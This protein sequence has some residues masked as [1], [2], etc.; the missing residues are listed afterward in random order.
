[1]ILKYQY[2]LPATF[3]KQGTKRVP[4]LIVCKLKKRY[5]RGTVLGPQQIQTL[6]KAIDRWRICDGPHSICF[7]TTSSSLK[8]EQFLK[9]VLESFSK[10]DVVFQVSNTLGFRQ[11]GFLIQFITPSPH[12]GH[13]LQYISWDMM[14]NEMLV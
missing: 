5:P 8:L 4:Y 3:R 10:P 12:Q 14:K 7:F 11:T 1:M 2:Y 6:A 13:L 9:L